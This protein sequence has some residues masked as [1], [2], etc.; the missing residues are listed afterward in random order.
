M[1]SNAQSRALVF[2]AV[3]A[4]VFSLT[5]I[6][7]GVLSGS[8]MI[9]FDSAYSLLSLL[10]ASMSL[11][12]LHLAR[13]PASRRFPFGRLTAEPLTILVKGVVIGAMCVSSMVVAMISIW[14]GGR[15]VNLDIALIFGGFN[16]LGCCLTWWVLRRAQQKSAAPLLGAEVRQ[17]QMDTWLS[18]AVLMG[19]LLA[20]LLAWS[21]WSAWAVYAD[22]VM[23]LIIAGYFCFI[24]LQMIRQAL[25]QLLLGAPD[26]QISR[27]LSQAL[28]SRGVHNFRLAQVGSFV[29]L[30]CDN[31]VL[32][33]E[34]EGAFRATCELHA[35]RPIFVHPA[36]M[37]TDV[38]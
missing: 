22:P 4:S 36:V 25:H 10:L 30:Q 33:A 8:V 32:S 9:I 24:P 6:V 13:Q 29:I 17:W 27:A 28:R 18:A 3:S 12:A 19:F 21:P 14:Q 35:L 1:S 7:L 11:W 20:Q 23:V 15:E 31:Q 34:L 37:T 38:A 16:V 26:T 5:G 2:S